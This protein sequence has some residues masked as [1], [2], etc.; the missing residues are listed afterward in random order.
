MWLIAHAAESEGG[1]LAPDAQ[2]ASPAASDSR[3]SVA[4]GPVAA[5]S[6]AE[7]PA[8]WLSTRSFASAQHCVAALREERCVLW[9]TALGQSATELPAVL[10]DGTVAASRSQPSSGLLSDG[11]SAKGSQRGGATAGSRHAS[12]LEAGAPATD[13]SDAPR[14]RLAVAFSGSE[15]E[16][17]SREL[18]DAAEQLVYLP[19]HGAEPASALAQ[20]SPQARRHC[21]GRVAMRHPHH[22]MRQA[23][24][25]CCCSS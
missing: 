14:R 17:V 3:Q 19:L 6:A 4:A 20:H 25:Q 5:V 11:S 9:C 12:S 18:L 21:L 13:S 15:A 10:R 16:G 22:V 2:P 24:Q 8:Q 7:D 23:S 1:S